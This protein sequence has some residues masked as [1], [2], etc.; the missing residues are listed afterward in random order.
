[1]R[2]ASRCNFVDQAREETTLLIER[3]QH[4]WLT[5]EH[6]RAVV[7]RVRERGAREDETIEERH[8]EREARTLQRTERAVG[9]GA[10]EDHI[11]AIAHEGGWDRIGHALVEVNDVDHE[12]L[13]EE[14]MD[15]SLL[16][17]AAL[18]MTTQLGFWK[19]WVVGHHATMPRSGWLIPARLANSIQPALGSRSM[20][21]HRLT[22]PTASVRTSHGTRAERIA[23]L[24]EQEIRRGRFRERIPSVRTLA[25]EF[26]VDRE[27]V[28]RALSSL[29]AEGWLEAR[30]REGFFVPAEVPTR[31]LQGGALH[32]MRKTPSYALY[33]PVAS[34][35][36]SAVPPLLDLSTGVPDVR[37]AP[38]AALARAYKEALTAPRQRLGYG[39]PRG[40]VR[41]RRALATMLRD[42][43]ALATQEDDVVV[44]H[45]SQHAI[46]L[47]ARVL[48]RPGDRV[49]VE[50]PGYRPAWST[51]QASGASLVALP[52]DAR[53]LDTSALEAVLREGSIRAIYVTPHHQY[54]TM[55]V[56]APERRARLLEL[57]RAHRFAILEDDYDHEHHFEGPPIAPLAAQDKHGS[58]LYIGS[59]SK[60]FAPGLRIGFIAA[61]RALLDAVSALRFASDRQGD[62]VL[63]S[64]L[65][66]LMEAGVIEQHLRRVRRH[67][68][69]RRTHMIEG[70]TKLFGARMNLT[71]PSGG[72]ALW[73]RI[74]ESK[75]W[76]H[77]IASKAREQGARV[78]IGSAFTLERDPLPHLRIGFA[79]LDHEEAT[80]ALGALARADAGC[81]R[82]AAARR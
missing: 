51:L 52:V 50:V 66:G 71:L 5:E 28:H 82:V 59:L 79:W 8:R 21:A 14:R 40:D 41:L 29:V 32:G 55:H 45:G 6:G 15:G 74:E 36:E 78:D 10:V 75:A 11:L 18:G 81:R 3:S 30:A 38:L 76:W 17:G 33:P 20:R 70:L 72:L 53:G 13:I 77:A 80:K 22:L 46:D 56:M 65:A 63:Q 1:M 25:A 62:H 39:D 60:L 43:R 49:A 27:T 26:E 12:R 31:L 37:L 7:H 58:V 68:L 16:V 64:A 57:A 67:F 61:P 42:T 48:I 54:P 47:V 44:T 24:V 34:L 2:R 69:A 35:V 9:H 19:H 4:T 23:A 73:P